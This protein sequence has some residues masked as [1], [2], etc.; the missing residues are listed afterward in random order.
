M[1][2]GYY[3]A[4]DYN[5]IT[6]G[7]NLAVDLKYYFTC[8]FFA[9]SFASFGENSYLG[10]TITGILNTN[11]YGSGTNA[12]ISN[13]IAGHTFGYHQKIF[14][15]IEISVQAGIGSYTQINTYSFHY[16]NHIGPY[17]T[18]FTDFAFPF[19]AGIGVSLIKNLKLGLTGG[20]NFLPD[21]PF[22][23]TYT[24][25]RISYAFE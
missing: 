12:E 1:Q 5:I 10:N 2:G 9:S 25:P 6:P 21:Y 23:G 15:I 20:S 7:N 22:V 8:N 24:G 11:D 16:K 3:K 4:N 19:K 14:S 17:Q 13:I 18:A